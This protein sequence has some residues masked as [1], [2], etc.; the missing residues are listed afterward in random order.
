MA[1][2]CLHTSGTSGWWLIVVVVVVEED[3]FER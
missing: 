2:M 3:E 1:K